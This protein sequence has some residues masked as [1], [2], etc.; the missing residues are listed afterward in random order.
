[1]YQNNRI[2]VVR[3]QRPSDER[4]TDLVDCATTLEA[5]HEL[6]WRH[7][8]LNG[9]K[10]PEGA[11]RPELINDDFGYWFMD[12]ED[13]VS[14]IRYDIQLRDIWTERSVRKLNT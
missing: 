13:D 12:C 1:M 7:F 6:A 8:K 3:V 2:F 9:I 11:T 14:W 10:V 4:V 5:A